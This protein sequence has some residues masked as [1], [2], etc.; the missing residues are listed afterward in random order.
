MAKKRKS[1]CMPS[2]FFVAATAITSLVILPFDTH[3][4]PP[5]HSPAFLN[6]LTTN[7]QTNKRHHQG[8]V[9]LRGVPTGEF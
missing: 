5:P 6:Q 3:I 9:R 1:T 2:L 8:L 7:K 4:F